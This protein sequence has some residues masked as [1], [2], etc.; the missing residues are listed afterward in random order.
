MQ[1]RVKGAVHPKMKLRYVSTFYLLS[2]IQMVL[3]WI[4]R[5]SAG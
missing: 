2:I 3:Q 4:S 5:N 1:F